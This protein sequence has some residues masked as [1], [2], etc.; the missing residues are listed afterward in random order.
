MSNVNHLGAVYKMP[1]EEFK[2]QI[3][4]SAVSTTAPKGLVVTL[5]FERP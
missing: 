4:L 5:E 3:D 1:D 2:V